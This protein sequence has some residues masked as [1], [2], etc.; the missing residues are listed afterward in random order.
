MVNRKTGVTSE[1]KSL[2]HKSLVEDMPE[3]ERTYRPQ[4]QALARICRPLWG[5]PEAQPSS[6]DNIAVEDTACR[7]PVEEEQRM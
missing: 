3:V 4:D 7:A 1:R 5:Q 6:S 2:E